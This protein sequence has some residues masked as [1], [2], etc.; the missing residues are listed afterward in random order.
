M[1]TSSVLDQTMYVAWDKNMSF[2]RGYDLLTASPAVSAL[3]PTK[4]S[5]SDSSADQTYLRYIRNESDFRQEVEARVSGSAKVEGVDAKASADFLNK[6]SYSSN[7]ETLIVTWTS[8]AS[9][10]ER[11]D[12]PKLTPDAA[13]LAK[14]TEKFRLKYGD[15]FVNGGL[16]SAH[17]QAMYVLKAQSQSQLT[18]FEAAMGAS[19]PEVFTA[20]VSNK[21]QQEAKANSISITVALDYTAASTINRPQL[22]AQMSPADIV[23]VWDWFKANQRNDYVVAELVH[24]STLDDRLSRT[25]PVPP[26]FFANAVDVQFRLT[27]CHKLLT[28]VPKKLAADRNWDE[29]VAE[30]EV[31]VTRERPLWW[32][33]P[34]DLAKRAKAAKELRDQLAPIA[35]FFGR[36]SRLSG[37]DGGKSHI[38]GRDGGE[39]GIGANGDS[40]M[41]P[42]GIE[43]KSKTLSINDKWKFGDSGNKT[44]HVTFNE[45]GSRIVYIKVASGYSRDTRGECTRFSGGLNH[46]N[47]Y[48]GFQADFDRGLVWSVTLRYVPN[49]DPSVAS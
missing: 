30:M 38:L 32:Q 33:N 41:V 22:P 7:S 11:I 35:D 45:P 27:Q 20:D 47:L 17:F 2:G 36:V 48:A 26:E 18:K 13:A 43:L 28:Q 46:D 25:V 34:D 10:F 37:T 21:F 42:A 24:Y 29:K 16:R 8:N 15:Y 49:C 39:V 12:G 19:M 4:S 44:G 31:A 6:A 9:G 40:S 14:D 5:P 23:K 3:A 1:N